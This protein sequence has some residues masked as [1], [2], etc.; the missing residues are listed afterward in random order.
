MKQQQSVLKVN[1]ALLLFCF[2]LSS[3]AWSADQSDERILF[4]TLKFDKSSVQLVDS[5]I[6]LGHLKTNR[7]PSRGEIQYEL[8]GDS[9]LL[10][11]GAIADPLVQHLEYE[12]PD[13]TGKILSKVIA[14]PEATITLRVPYSA[15]INQLSFYR[16]EQTDGADSKAT[17][18]TLGIIDLTIVHRGER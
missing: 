18:T 11:Q 7:G 10:L 4:L 14:W 6:V 16:T 15:A 5:K 12:D 13:N 3:I 2:L 17:R 1:V 8:L 9:G